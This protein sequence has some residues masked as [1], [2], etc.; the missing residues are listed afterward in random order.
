M[1]EVDQCFAQTLQVR[2]CRKLGTVICGDRPYDIIPV[3]ELTAVIHG[4]RTFLDAPVKDPLV[5][6]V[7]RLFGRSA[8][9]LR[10]IDIFDSE[11]AG[12]GVAVK[13]FGTDDLVS[14]KEPFFQ[15]ATD[16]SIQ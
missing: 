5:F 16:T 1:G 11:K 10:E 4:C 8:K 14:G 7:L 2:Q 12:S 13:C 15:S 9:F 3:S 6:T